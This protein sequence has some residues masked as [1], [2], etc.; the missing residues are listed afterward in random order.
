MNKNLVNFLTLLKN[1]SL[2][3]KKVYIVNILECMKKY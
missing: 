3:K 2:K 1:A